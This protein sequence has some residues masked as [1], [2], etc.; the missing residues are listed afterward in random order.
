MKVKNGDQ[1]TTNEHVKCHQQMINTTFIIAKYKKETCYFINFVYK[2][3]Q[4]KIVTE[5]YTDTVNGKE[6]AFVNKWDVLCVCFNT[7]FLK[8]PNCE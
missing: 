4:K 8:Y 6:D 2:F 1:T 3:K 7:A 5:R